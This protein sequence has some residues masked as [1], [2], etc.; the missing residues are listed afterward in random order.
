MRAFVS[1]TLPSGRFEATV[2]E[3]AG[4]FFVEWKHLVPDPRKKQITSK[5]KMWPSARGLFRIP[6][7]EVPRWL[8]WSSFRLSCGWTDQTYEA[9]RKAIEDISARRAAK[10]ATTATS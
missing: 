9:V 6:D 7:G 3:G 8:G 4:A 2:S 5:V 1:V 10:R